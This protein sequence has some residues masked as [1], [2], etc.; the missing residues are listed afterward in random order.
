MKM[1]L[2]VSRSGRDGCVLRRDARRLQERSRR[3]QAGRAARS[4]KTHLEPPESTPTDWAAVDNCQRTAASARGLGRRTQQPVDAARRRHD[5][6]QRQPIGQY[7][8]RMPL[9]HSETG[10]R[11][12]LT[13][14]M[15]LVAT[16][17]ERGGGAP[18]ERLSHVRFRRRV[19]SA[20]TRGDWR[21]RRHDNR[22][23]RKPWN[24]QQSAARAQ[25]GSR[26][27]D[28]PTEAD[29]A[30]TFA[31]ARCLWKACGQRKTKPAVTRGRFQIAPAQHGEDEEQVCSASRRERMQSK[32]GHDLKLERRPDDL[33]LAMGRVVS[34]LHC[35]LSIAGAGRDSEAEAAITTQKA[36][37]PP[38]DLPFPG[39]G[40]TAAPN[41]L[42]NGVMIPTASVHP[43]APSRR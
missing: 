18:A 2:A 7:V 38:E 40:F 5:Q 13:P 37:G 24:S 41:V 30:R 28:F 21:N 42:R 22:K 6:R 8:A 32:P 1:T 14:R 31:E 15:L 19:T 12:A 33:A 29:H 35:R 9:A 10:A 11:I 16:R 39:G 36:D 20:M 25:R 34:R 3:G 17:A 4:A 26:E 43:Q 27:A 23:R